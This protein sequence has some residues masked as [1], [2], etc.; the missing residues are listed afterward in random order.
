MG[1]LWFAP[2]KR[3]IPPPTS[4]QQDAKHPDNPSVG[5]T[6]P[7]EVKRTLSREEQA[8]EDFANMMKEIQVEMDKDRD[9]RP[10]SS[11]STARVLAAPFPTDINS[12]SVYPISIHCKSAFDFAMFCSAFGGQWVNVYRYGTYRS[13]SNHW[14]D[15]YLCMRTRNWDEKDRAKA[16]KEHYQKKAVKWKTGPSSEDIWEVRTEPAPKDFFQHNLEELEEKVREWK[17]QNPTA[18]DPWEKKDKAV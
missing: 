14:D 13:C 6:A 9:G 18:I 8:N 5:L 15:F 10:H 1:W 11:T 3:E 12:E 4:S 2:P 17:R 16:I 7:E